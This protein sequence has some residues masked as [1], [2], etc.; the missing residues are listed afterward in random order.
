MDNNVEDKMDYKLLTG[1]A[2]LPLSQKKLLCKALVVHHDMA[3]N[4]TM[5]F[6][7]MTTDIYMTNDKYVDL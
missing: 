1:C 4:N 6:D 5:Y 7:Y 2:I 3:T